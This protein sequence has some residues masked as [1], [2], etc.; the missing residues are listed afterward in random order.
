MDEYEEKRNKLIDDFASEIDD[1]DYKFMC[2]AY[3]ICIVGLSIFTIVYKLKYERK[4]GFIKA[5]K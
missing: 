4:L 2:S 1:F 3:A 5:T